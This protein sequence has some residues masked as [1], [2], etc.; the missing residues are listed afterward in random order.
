MNPCVQGFDKVFGK[1]FLV[2]AILIRVAMGNDRLETVGLQY[3][4]PIT[5]TPGNFKFFFMGRFLNTFCVEWWK[6]QICILSDRRSTRVSF[7]PYPI[8]FIH[9]C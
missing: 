3:L 1:E 5:M 6:L 2:F 9:Y 4:D 7:W 8:V